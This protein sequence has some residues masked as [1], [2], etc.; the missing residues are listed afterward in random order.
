MEPRI[1]IGN[2]RRTRQR[3]GWRLRDLLRR[4]LHVLGLPNSGKSVWLFSLVKQLIDLGITVILFDCKGDLFFWTLRYLTRQR[5]GRRSVVIDPYDA[6]SGVGRVAVCNLY[7]E[8]GNPD[9]IAS[10]CKSA[11]KRTFRTAAAELMPWLDHSL[12]LGG[13]LLAS[14]RG[15]NDAPW[16]IYEL[17]DVLRVGVSPLRDRLLEQCP[18]PA[19][20]DRLVDFLRLPL[21]ERSKMLTPLLVRL[22]ELRASLA[23]SGA[24]GGSRVTYRDDAVLADRRGAIL[25]A[26]LYDARLPPD[27][28]LFLGSVLL[29]RLQ[30]AVFRRPRT[31]W[32]RPVFLVIDEVQKLVP[33]GG[34]ELLDF[35]ER[36]RSFGLNVVCSH[37]FCGQLVP[38]DGDLRLRDGLTQIAQCRVYFSLGARD[39]LQGGLTDE[40]YLPEIEDRTGEKKH[41]TPAYRTRL[42]EE[43]RRVRQVSAAESASWSEGESDSGG[44]GA[45]DF[46]SSGSSFASGEVA[47]SALIYP[48]GEGLILPAGFG[49]AGA[50]TEA[51]ARSSQSA[52]S[53]L[54][55]SGTMDFSGWATSRAR[56][57]GTTRG[58]SEAVVPWL[59]PVEVVEEGAPTFYSPEEA[60]LHYARRLHR[61][62]QRAFVF[63][64]GTES[65]CE[66]FSPRVEF[67]HVFAREE[68]AFKAAIYP[69]YTV[70]TAQVLEEL[71]TR[72]P[73]FLAAA[74]AAEPEEPPRSAA[75]A[76]DFR[77]R[78]VV[79][80][81][82]LPE[83]RRR[84]R[85]A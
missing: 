11:F 31:D 22:F 23:V 53:D 43:T 40:V 75:G 26:R 8:L 32:D 77:D 71:R 9:I 49:P 20:R 34:E 72:V 18:E 55:G 84:K 30:A 5:L 85:Q 28:L 46:A 41:I 62:P 61:Q 3:R 15:P 80:E 7:D 67:P 66:L 1:W 27:D 83:P 52:W 81:P 68:T 78:V 25:A 56:G 14:T 35:L 2:D 45:S 57:G 42:V 29:Q 50:L 10:W 44:T 37:Q 19:V 70:P 38:A 54:H 76:D 58:T 64:L 36:S 33:A 74:Q 65:A 6:V 24:L 13:N 12:T 59:R 63:Q 60:R 39:A 4:H 17:A 79:V 16:T 51:E 82:P 69:R 73:K 48:R 47:S 21:A